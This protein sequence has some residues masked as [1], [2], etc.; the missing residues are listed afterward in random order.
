MLKRRVVLAAAAVG[1]LA[2]VATT[3]AAIAPIKE[4]AVGL[5][6]EY[7]TKRLLSVGDT[8]PETGNAGRPVQDGRHPGRSRGARER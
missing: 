4:Y 2:V 7:Q 1:V 5:G 6:G 3:G 8:V